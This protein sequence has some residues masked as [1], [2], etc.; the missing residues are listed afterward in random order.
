MNAYEEEIAC[1]GAVQQRQL[2]EAASTSVPVH[3]IVLWYHWCN[4]LWR[5]WLI[6]VSAFFNP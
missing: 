1:S 6:G 5:S 2:V 4:C 3:V